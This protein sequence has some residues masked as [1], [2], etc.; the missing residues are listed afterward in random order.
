MPATG[1][2]GIDVGHPVRTAGLGAARPTGGRQRILRGRYAS[3]RA[4]KD[5]RAQ[6]ESESKDGAEHLGLGPGRGQP[7][8]TAQRLAEENTALK[9]RIRQ[10]TEDN[11]A[12]PLRSQRSVSE[13][14]FL[15]GDW[16]LWR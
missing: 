7:P 15:W 14:V 16:P 12:G 5:R 8:G 10:L 1:W 6:P 11:R 3:A 2:P 9:Q 4:N 13:L